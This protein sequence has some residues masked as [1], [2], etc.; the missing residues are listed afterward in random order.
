MEFNS[1]TEFIGHY[2]DNKIFEVITENLES[3][4]SFYFSVSFVMESGLNLLIPFIK[5]ALDRGC[6]G[7]IITTDYMKI[8]TSGVLYKF[9]DLM[10]NYSNFHAY[11]LETKRTDYESFHT[12][13]YIFTKDNVASIIIGSSNM[14][15]TALGSDGGEWSLFTKTTKNEHLF[16]EVD[17]ELR[18]NIKEIGNI[19]T[20][21][22]VQR[23]VSQTLDIVYGT[24]E[25]N[26]MQKEA[27][28]ALNDIRINKNKKR[29]LV[30]AAMA[31]GKT[32]LSAF[33]AKNQG[34]KHILYLCHSESIL[35]HARIE[36]EN[37]FGN[38]KTYGFFLGDEK[39]C[40]ADI[41]FATNSSLSKHLDYFDK[42]YFGYIVFDEAH[43]TA[44]RTYQLILQYFDPDFILGMTGTP[45]RTDRANVKEIF[46]NSIPYE[47]SL[48]DAIKYDLVMPFKYYGIKDNL[49]DYSKKNENVSFISQMVTEEH[50]LF[51][52]QHIDAHLNEITGK[53]KCLAFC[54]TVE[55][56]KK[57]SE[58]MN[59]LGYISDYIYGETDYKKRNDVYRN[60]QDEKNAL[61]IVFS[62]N[63][64]NEGVDLPKVNMALFLRPTESSI[65]FIQQ[66]GRSL[67]KAENK[68][69][70]VII[71]FVGNKYD[72]SIYIAWALGELIEAP[73]LTK[74]ILKTILSSNN[75]ALENLGVDVNFDSESKKEINDA[76]K[77]LNFNSLDILKKSFEDHKKYCSII[78]YP[79]HYS[80]VAQNS[81]F[82]LMRIIMNHKSYY[83]FLERIHENNLPRFSKSEI[84]FIDYLSSF[85][86]LSRSY[87]YRI[88][89]A[90]IENE[91]LDIE[92]LMTIVKDE[93]GD[94]FKEFRFK[95]ALD[96]LELKT[97][98]EQTQKK[99]PKYLLQDENR[100]YFL[101]ISLE[102][103]K[104]YYND[105][106]AELDFN[107]SEFRCFILDLLNYGIR[108]FEQDNDINDI[109]F[110]LYNSYS[111][112]EFTRV[113]CF[114]SVYSFQPG[115]QYSKND[116]IVGIFVDLIKKENVEEHLNYGDKFAS[117]RL[118][119]WESQTYT[120]IG[121]KRYQ[122]LIECNDVEI[123]VRKFQNEDGVNLPYVYLGKA[124][125]TNPRNTSN[126][127]QTVKFDILLE[128][129]L[130]E[131]LFNEFN[132]EQ[133]N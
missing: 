13:G 93:I 52:K 108:K 33:D 64:M 37:V 95:H 130:P 16:E 92:T 79:T 9:I 91:K 98:S 48:R 120:V 3:C 35:R 113:V 102:D 100:A 32:Y 74:P 104:E 82:D 129:E 114:D 71:D 7:T 62:V 87:E 41:I 106:F 39:N 10:K 84:D 81:G 131:E 11:F 65:V 15:A 128:N 80:F 89:R 31:S 22:Q 40:K 115:V 90:L 94:K 86:P 45:D 4:D 61:Q 46:G 2:S 47:L 30:V 1:R 103:R 51:V 72:R 49:V 96:C 8:T 112:K 50:G 21:E 70:P 36:Y 101:N 25:P 124:K 6:F 28:K 132:I 78:T 110:T 125:L 38:S 133:E 127:K 55:H 42:N 29:A 73:V 43:H 27:L 119:E 76:L 20:E 59:K 57:M 97:E 77:K 56:A 123:F 99:M 109:G 18:N 5:N 107:N 111:R 58:L 118:L 17:L 117:K 44:A 83:H 116:D 126:I 88:V 12:K 54:S 67:R 69:K 53:L 24:I 85:L 68:N 66:L 122:R 23:Y 75:R 60:L 63:V 105:E 14:S 121:N 19:L 34:A 26:F